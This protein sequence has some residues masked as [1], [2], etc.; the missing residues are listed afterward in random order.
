MIYDRVIMEMA[1][2]SHAGLAKEALLGEMFS[3]YRRLIGM[4]IYYWEAS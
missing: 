3:Y 2:N 4:N 1:I